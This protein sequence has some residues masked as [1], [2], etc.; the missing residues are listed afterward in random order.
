MTNS[1]LYLILGILLLSFITLY[2]VL[3]RKIALKIFKKDISQRWGKTPIDQY[4]NE[5]LKAISSYYSNLIIN[6]KGTH[7]IDDITWNDLEMDNVFKR[8]NNTQTSVGEEFLY[9]LLREPVF[10]EKILEERDRLIDYFR[11]S[12]VEREKLQII[13][14]AMGKKRFVGISDYFF[15]NIKISLKSR[16]YIVLSFCFL[17]SPFALIINPTFGF[18]CMAATFIINVL[19]YYKMKNKMDFYLEGIGY[20]VG[21]IKCS[22]KIS[23]SNI[24]MINKYADRLN[25]LVNK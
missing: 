22:R 18:L 10:D 17:I 1:L 8:I 15:N 7:F 13:L 14:A 6:K 21:L 3:K 16:H 4:K 5:D 12:N 20:I 24:S 19:V 25:E 11:I 2:N 23:N 9:S